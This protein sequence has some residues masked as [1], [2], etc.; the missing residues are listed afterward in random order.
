M[1][2]SKARAAT[3]ADSSRFDWDLIRSFLAAL[4]Q[5][6]LLGAARAL[7]SSQPTV[8][9]HISELERQLGTALFERTGRGLRPTGAAL[10]LAD[11]ARD[12]ERAALQL[13]Q[14]VANTQSSL[15]GTVRITA[16]TPVSCYLLPA[17]LARMQLDLPEIQV[18]LVSSNAVSNLLRREA[19]IAVRMV[20]PQQASL[21]AK[22]I[23]Q[24]PVGAYAHT[25]YLRRRGIPRQHADLLRH[26]LVGMDQDDQ[27]I[28]GFQTFGVP[29]TK[30]SFGVRCDDLIAYL[31]L[32]RAGVGIGF[33]GSYMARV[34]P[35]LQAVL[36]DLPIPPLPMWLA[37]HREV[38][39]N[40]RIRAVYDYL[41]QALPEVL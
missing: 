30:A 24:V 12:M 13:V 41:A 2:N 22:R 21:I 32:V 4:E 14:G 1:N 40:A 35:A 11:A 29:L 18:E 26:A 33:L 20:P 31:A 7:K 34:D 17:I 39:G 8:G 15:A 28:K 36:P 3:R 9:R 38:R 19:D 25:D 10:N 5:G 6:S 23:G 37:V 27:I 16:S